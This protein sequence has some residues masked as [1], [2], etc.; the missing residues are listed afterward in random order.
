MTIERSSR[1]VSAARIRRVARQL[2]DASP[3][4]AIATVSRGGRAHVNTAYFAWERDFRLFWISDPRGT[5][6]R[7]VRANASVAIAV[8]DSSQS[9]GEPDRG[10]Q[11]FGSAREVTA[12]S[13]GA[14]KRSYAKRFP[15][16]REAEL[17]GYAPYEFRPIRMKLFDERGRSAPP[18]S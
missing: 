7:H 10:I 16:Y 4:C 3:L 18:S 15:D 1:R 5:H 12:D 13:V 6:S 11:L 8:Y 9:W 2:L 17:G 14:A